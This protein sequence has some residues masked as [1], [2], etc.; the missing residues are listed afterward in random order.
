MSLVILS[1]PV[2][3]E[4]LYPLGLP[5]LQLSDVPSAAPGQ[6]PGSTARRATIGYSHAPWFHLEITNSINSVDDLEV[7]CFASSLVARRPSLRREAGPASNCA[8][9]VHGIVA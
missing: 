1:R 7:G 3:T 9:I 5:D 4:V 8:K 6:Q 2:G